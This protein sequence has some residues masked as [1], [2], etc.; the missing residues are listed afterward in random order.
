[1]HD[2]CISSCVNDDVVCISGCIDD[3]VFTAPYCHTV[4]MTLATLSH[5]KWGLDRSSKVSMSK[6]IAFCLLSSW[7]CT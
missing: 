6:K 1:M 4:L 2:V 5:S 3:D 7:I